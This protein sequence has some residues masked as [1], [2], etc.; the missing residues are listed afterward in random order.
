MWKKLSDWVDSN[1][2]EYSPRGCI[3]L[4]FVCLVSYLFLPIESLRFSLVNITAAPWSVI[5]YLLAHADIYHLYSNLLFLILF[6]FHVEKH[7]GTIKFIKAFLFCGAV[8]AIANGV[9]LPNV[10]LVGASGAVSGIMAIAPFTIN[11]RLTR[12]TFLSLLCFFMYSNL[13]NV[14]LQEFTRTAHI[15]HLAGVVAG[16]YWWGREK[17]KNCF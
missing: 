4:C 8:S 2:R 15:A 3:L 10:Y 1:E 7:I 11:N 12:L 13:Y 9:F 14:A 16:M 5:T 17:A 6:G